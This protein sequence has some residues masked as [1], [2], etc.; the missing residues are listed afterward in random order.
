MAVKAH[1]G[2]H[3]NQIQGLLLIFTEILHYYVQNA[4]ISCVF[5][6]ARMITSG[7]SSSQAVRSRFFRSLSSKQRSSISNCILVTQLNPLVFKVFSIMHSLEVC[8]GEKVRRALFCL[9]A[10]QSGQSRIALYLKLQPSAHCKQ[11]SGREDAGSKPSYVR[12]NVQKLVAFTA[13]TSD[14]PALFVQCI[15]CLQYVATTQNHFPQALSY[16]RNSCSHHLPQY[17]DFS[18]RRLG[19]NSLTM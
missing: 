4:H 6:H 19:S 14:G 8:Q 7:V 5:N 2:T 12:F 17:E 11:L 10:L 1:T 9:L 15:S 3:I 13:L 18:Y 16:L